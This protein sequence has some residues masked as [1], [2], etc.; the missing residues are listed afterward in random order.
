MMREE[1]VGIQH[2]G[3][4]TIDTQ[5]GEWPRVADGDAGSETGGAQVG[6]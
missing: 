1:G 3:M 6:G 5:V 4:E 2:D